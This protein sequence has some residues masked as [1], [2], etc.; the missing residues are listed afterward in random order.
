MLVAYQDGELSHDAGT[1]VARHLGRC[2]K[3]LA[4]AGR[5]AEGRALLLATDAASAVPCEPML[6]DLSRLLEQ[7][8]T[9]VRDFE[10]AGGRVESSLIQHLRDTAA[11]CLGA[12]AAE[13][14]RQH[15][16]QAH[17]ETAQSILTAFLGRR[18]A[19]RLL[20]QVGLEAGCLSASG[21]RA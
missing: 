15:A 1:C 21:A 19:G 12:G 18:A 4:L 16:S 2:V 9:R 20:D 14:V 5:L 7:A 13:L 17:G 10:Q 6:P 3:C 11:V 8:R